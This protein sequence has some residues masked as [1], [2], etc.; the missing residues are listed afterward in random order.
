VKRFAIS[1]ALSLIVVIVTKKKGG[2]TGALA[3]LPVPPFLSIP[4]SGFVRF[5]H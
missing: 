4:P 1:A 5:V 2:R 3:L